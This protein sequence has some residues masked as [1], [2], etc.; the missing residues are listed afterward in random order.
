MSEK[1]SVEVYQSKVFE[2]AFNKLD[3]KQ[4]ILV[5]DEI[6]LIIKDPEL[7]KL[8][9]G[10][11]SYLRVHKFKLNGP[12]VLLGYHWADEKIELYL[13]NIG[14][15]DNFYRDEKSRTKASLALINSE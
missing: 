9:K 2:K 11:L 14:S 12:E 5:D 3:D 6:G 15:H 1:K 7:G 10:D 4:Q 13:L 8:K